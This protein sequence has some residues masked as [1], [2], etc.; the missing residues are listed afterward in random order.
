MAST[1]HNREIIISEATKKKM[2]SP[3]LLAGRCSSSKSSSPRYNLPLMIQLSIILSCIVT[4]CNGFQSVT[5]WRSSTTARGSN[6]P[7]PTSMLMM[8]YS[9]TSCCSSRRQKPLMMMAKEDIIQG[10]GGI[11]R[12]KSHSSSSSMSSCK[13]SNSKL[14]PQRK[15][16]SSRQFLLPMAASSDKASENDPSSSN[17]E[18]VSGDDNSQNRPLL[19]KAWLSLRKLLARFWALLL[20]PFQ[21]LKSVLTKQTKDKDDAMVETKKDDD[22]EESIQEEVAITEVENIAVVEEDIEEKGKDD[23]VAVAEEVVIEQLEEVEAETAVEASV[24]PPTTEEM[25]ASETTTPTTD[26]IK[27]P[28]AATTAAVSLTGNWTLIVDESFTSQ[29]ENYLRKLG[30]PMLVRTVAQTVI[31]STKEETIQS[32]DGQKLYIRGMNVR[33]SWERTLEASEQIDD[34]QDGGKEKKHA[35][36]GH[37]LK[38]MTTADGEDVEVASWWENNGKVH[39]SWVVGGKKYGGGDFENKRYLTDNGNI[40]VCESTFHPRMRDD[41]DTVEVALGQGGQEVEREKASVTWRFLREGAIYGDAAMEFPNIF[42]VLKKDEK[43]QK[44]SGADEKDG[45][46]ALPESGV[47]VGDIMDVAITS[48]DVNNIELSTTDKDAVAAYVIEEAIERESWVPPSGDRWAIAAPNVNLSGKW[49]LIITK[50]FTK[51][52]EEFLTSLGQPLIVRGAA[53][54]LIGN[55]REET[56]QSDG[57]RSMYIKGVNAKGVWERSLTSSGSDFDT[58]MKPD[59]KDGSYDHVQVPIET[60]DSEKVVAESWWEDGGTVHVSWT[61]GV[62]RYGGGSFESKRYLENDGNVYVCESTFHPNDS[63]RREK[64]FLKWK[65]LREGSAFMIKDQQ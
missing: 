23:V 57:G 24:S 8:P 65:F 34:D 53:V 25:E 5:P 1:L 13:S 37:E 55:T 15:T 51:K 10:G 35:V 11:N 2:K 17:N 6:S 29:Y 9:S 61:Y 14:F 7:L 28:R 12:C 32:E 60:A 43:D 30:Q 48:D 39:H 4:S 44:G 27:P 50:Q 47:V 54:A 45:D 31:G 49:K 41:E 52:Y 40:L 62:T 3:S 58:T 46:G 33:G 20:K 63:N 64:S 19:V 21:L 18:E 56:Q 22:K 42:D 36:Q 59:P 16:P 26:T 38:P